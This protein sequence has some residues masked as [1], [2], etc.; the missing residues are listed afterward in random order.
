M[1]LAAAFRVHSRL[2]PGLLKSAY[3]RV[4]AYELTK[5]G[6]RLKCKNRLQET[7]PIP[8]TKSPTHRNH[9]GHPARLLPI[10]KFRTQN[11]EVRSQNGER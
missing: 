3:Q 4:L 2:G 1:I 6:C 7:L 11:A 9:G 5:G 10:L 8:L